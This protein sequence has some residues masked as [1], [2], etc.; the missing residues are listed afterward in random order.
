MIGLLACADAP[1]YFDADDDALPTITELSIACDDATGDWTFA[2]TTDAW[3]GNALVTMSADGRYVEAH[4]LYAETSAADGTWDELAMTLASQP[5]VH[6]V[7]E[8][9]STY[10]NCREPGLT[11]VLQVYAQDGEM[12]ADCRGFI[13]DSASWA[14]WGFD[15]ACDESYAME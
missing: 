10:F 14:A 11:G 8:G 15:L 13:G 7:S 1:L 3:T 2:V 4:K 6:A 9:S 5:D 12:V